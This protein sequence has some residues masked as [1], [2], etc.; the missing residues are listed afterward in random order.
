MMVYSYL[1]ANISYIV[2]INN[3]INNFIL[4]NRENNPFYYPVILIIQNFVEK[5]INITGLSIL[6]LIRTRICY[7]LF[8]KVFAMTSCSYL[9]FAYHSPTLRLLHGNRQ[10]RELRHPYPWVF[11]SFSFCKRYTHHKDR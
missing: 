9:S 1:I 8:C 7:I 11:C 6:S 10:V 5:D 2:D 4:K 3:F